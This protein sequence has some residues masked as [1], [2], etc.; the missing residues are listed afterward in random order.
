MAA[1]RHH[2]TMALQTHP[3]LLEKKFTIASC[4]DS[5]VHYFAT[6]E[7]A[8]LP[9]LREITT[10]QEFHQ[11]SFP[12]EQRKNNWVYGFGWDENKWTDRNWLHRKT[13]DQRFPDVPVLLSRID[14]HSS[15]CNTQALVQLGFVAPQTLELT[16]LGK[17]LNQQHHFI[18]MDDVG[19]PIGILKE[20]PH[21]LAL[22]SMGD[23]TVAQKKS[24]FQQANGIFTAQ[25]YTHVRDMTSTM[26]QYQHLRLLE[27][28]KNLQINVDLN[29]VVESKEHFIHLLGDIKKIS[30]AE[31]SRIRVRGIKIFYDG[32]LGSRTALISGTYNNGNHGIALWSLEDVK[33][34]MKLS[35]QNQLEISVHT[36]GDEA[37]EQVVRVAQQVSQEGYVG[38]L[39]LEHLEICRPE[40]IQKMK[41]LHVRCHMQPAYW[42]SDKVWLQ[43]ELRA[44]QSNF[45]PWEALRAAKVDL[46]FGSD[47]PI[48][49]P[50]IFQIRHGLQDS[51]QN[52]IP[53]FRGN[54]ADFCRSPYKDQ[55][56]G[57][58]DFD[59]G[60]VAAVWFGEEKIYEQ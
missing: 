9:Q 36:L 12:V 26:D 51:A 37:I 50:S 34:V 31:S 41:S 4:Y 6:G 55:V 23:W 19:Q 24:M 8:L 18:E 42:L 49:A 2:L 57:H 33:S 47:S 40:T 25:G 43:S 54:F 22:Q 7:M 52:G 16:D 46:Q 1:I 17:R 15:W 3:S 10:V 60:Q 38:R 5:H 39:N 53:A 27:D 14:G 56:I 28:Q 48:E 11:L 59:H 45:F 13:L 30:A 32:S 35:F 58:S 20:T 21:I 29:F 44:M